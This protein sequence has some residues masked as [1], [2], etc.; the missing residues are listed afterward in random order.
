MI[1]KRCN[2]QL[3]MPNFPEADG[4]WFQKLNDICQSA[5]LFLLSL[6][7]SM[8]YANPLLK[9]NGAMVRKEH[10]IYEII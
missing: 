1:L 8:G 4:A 10:L 5:F 2:A 7:Q 6:F 3:R 9:R